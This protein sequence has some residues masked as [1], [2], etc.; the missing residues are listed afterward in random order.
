MGKKFEKNFFFKFELK[1]IEFKKV[2]IKKNFEFKKVWIK[3][4][5]N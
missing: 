5:L 4:N 3:K 1:K 2:W